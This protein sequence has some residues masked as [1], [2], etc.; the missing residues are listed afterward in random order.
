[1]DRCLFEGF[2][3][4]CRRP[5][6]VGLTRR[7]WYNARVRYFVAHLLSGEVQRYYGSLSRDF[8]FHY[9]ILPLSER[10]PAHLTVK[11]PFEADDEKIHAVERA[12]R[13]FAGQEK[14][15]S[16]KF[17]GFGHFGFRTIY[18][19]V[20][21]GD[22]VSMIRRGVDFLNMHLPWM[23]RSIHDGKKPHVSVAR[24]LTR[25]KSMRIWRQVKSL[26]PSISG[27]LD[28]IAILRK[29]GKRWV[30]HTLIP[31]GGSDNGFSYM[32][33]HGRAE[34]HLLY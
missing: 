21:N 27:E 30:L 24:F 8:A 10:V 5:W 3:E 4:I 25:T 17:S 6:R 19:D 13:A 22:A 16:L 9:K 34:A 23:P 7:S 33:P 28:N 18:L 14:P 31:L 15:V 29:E 2:D 26:S 11:P 32:H 1:M 12:L 20:E